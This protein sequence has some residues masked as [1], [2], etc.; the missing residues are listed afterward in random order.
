M[1]TP[2]HSLYKKPHINRHDSRMVM[3]LHNDF[4][5]NTALSVKQK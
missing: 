5:M 4:A 1:C 2:Y 3:M